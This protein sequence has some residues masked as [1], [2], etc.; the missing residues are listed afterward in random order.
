VSQGFRLK[1]GMVKEAS[2]WVIFKATSIFVAG[3]KIGLRVKPK[4]I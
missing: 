4:S 1:L 3:V 2:I